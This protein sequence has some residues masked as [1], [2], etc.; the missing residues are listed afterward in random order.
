[1]NMREQLARAI[2]IALVEKTMHHP[3]ARQLPKL[4]WLWPHVA[5]A[6]LSTLMSPTPEMIEAALSDYIGRF[7]AELVWQAMLRAAKGEG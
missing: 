6:I 5:D 1:M 2:E 4:Q 3:V 7:D